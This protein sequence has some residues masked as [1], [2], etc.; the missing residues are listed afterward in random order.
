MSQFSVIARLLQ[1]LS[2]LG[3]AF[4]LLQPTLLFSATLMEAETLSLGPVLFRTPADTTWLKA[5]LT[6]I[7]NAIV[8]WGLIH[9]SLFGNHLALGSRFTAAVSGS[10][11]KA[12]FLF[13]LG[14]LLSWL[15]EPLKTE[16][17]LFQTFLQLLENHGLLLLISI[18]FAL[19]SIL[20]KEAREIEAENQ[21]FY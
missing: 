18:A 11:R 16:Q 9:L 5:L 19:V 15:I 7:P 17:P 13:V 14:V 10:L 21:E 8:A 1:L 4:V 12:S 20:L 3:A 2:I 6:L